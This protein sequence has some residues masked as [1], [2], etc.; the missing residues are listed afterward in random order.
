MQTGLGVAKENAAEFNLLDPKTAGETLKTMVGNYMGKKILVVAS[1]AVL[2]QM[3][4]QEK[5]K[6]VAQ[7]IRRSHSWEAAALKMKEFLQTL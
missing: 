5:G 4:E 2:S 6:K 1:P 3:L 7:E